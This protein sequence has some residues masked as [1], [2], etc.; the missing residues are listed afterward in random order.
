M[1]IDFYQGKDDK[2]A[3]HKHQISQRTAATPVP[4]VATA[5]IRGGPLAPGIKGTVQFS[6]V[7]GGTWVSVYV[8]GLPPYQ[9]AGDAGRRLACGVIKQ[10][11]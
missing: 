3:V 6:P 10:G 9:P 8:E 4:T 2:V 1:E 7:Q 5:R 11:Y